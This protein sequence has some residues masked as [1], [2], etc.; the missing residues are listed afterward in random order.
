[1]ENGSSEFCV[2][3]KSVLQIRYMALQKREKLLQLD[4]ED[5]M[6]LFRNANTWVR[7]N[8]YFGYSALIKQNVEITVES[9]SAILRSIRLCVRYFNNEPHLLERHISTL[10]AKTDVELQEVERELEL[11][12]EHVKTSLRKYHAK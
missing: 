2:S 6:Y 10:N 4:R 8:D 5:D 9:C 12:P 3:D 11:L 7:T 1:M